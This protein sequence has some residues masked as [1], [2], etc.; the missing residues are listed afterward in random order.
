MITTAQI[1]TRESTQSC[2]KTEVLAKISGFGNEGR[3]AYTLITV[4]KRSAPSVLTP[5]SFLMTEASAQ[6]RLHHTI[7]RAA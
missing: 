3:S 4:G 7:V 6:P 5:S 1:L 2:A